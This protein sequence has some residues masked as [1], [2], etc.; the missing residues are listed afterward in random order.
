MAYLTQSDRAAEGAS[1]WQRLGALRTALTGRAAQHR[2]YRATRRELD[3]LGDRDLADLG[4]HRGQIR[5]VASVA[6]YRA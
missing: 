2:L 6:A 3:G 1:L 5:S 4:I